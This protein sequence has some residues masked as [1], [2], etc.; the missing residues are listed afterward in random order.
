MSKVKMINTNGEKVKDVTLNSDIWGVEPNDAVLYDAIRLTRNAQRQ[1]TS[2]TKTRSEVR[3][4]GAKPWRQ[5]GTGRARH[6]SIRSPLWTGGGIT[7][8]PKPRKY[9][10]KMNKK[11]RR[12]ALLSA[13][14]YKQLNKELIVLDELVFDTPKTKEMVSLLEKLN[15]TKKVLIV[16]EELTDNLVLASRNLEK[17]LLLQA[18]EVNTFDVVNADNM[19]VT[20]NAL[21]SLEEVLS[22]EK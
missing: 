19:I 15:V 21:K 5:K 9:D 1:G 12:L 8:G 13:L 4:G 11:E 6:G 10:F 17:V 3:G 7:F 2:S 22:Y 18:D 14:S 20:E 16:V